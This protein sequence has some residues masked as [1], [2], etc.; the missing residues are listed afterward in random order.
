MKVTNSTFAGNTAIQSQS[1]AIQNFGDT[2][3]LENSIFAGNACE[4]FSISDG[5]G[6]I[7]WPASS[8]P[9]VNADPRLGPLADNGGPTRT[10][11]IG[12]GGGAIDAALAA[13]CPS[14]DQRGISRPQGAG[15]D[16][17]AFESDAVDT[18]P[19]VITTPGDIVVDATGPSGAV[20]AYTASAIDDVDGSVG[21]TC[22]PPPGSTFPIETTHV[23]C[24]A[25]DAAGNEASASFDVHVKSAGEQLD[26]LIDRVSGIG[27]GSSL[28][29]KLTDAKSALVVGNETMACDKLVAFANQAKAQSGKTLTPAEAAE[30]VVTA[31]RIR[32]VLGC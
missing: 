23:T 6:N 4:G 31:N 9:G 17:G 14:T 20:V 25:S 5:G 13:V 12:L 3:T 7:A 29:E 15:C 16:I 18:T 21:V 1:G 30:F 19:P 2:I 28:T 8:C 26:D 10:M 27:P 22:S 32:S 24:N 11:A